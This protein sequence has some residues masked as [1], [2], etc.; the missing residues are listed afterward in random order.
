MTVRLL[1]C[2]KCLFFYFLYSS[3]NPEKNHNS[4]NRLIRKRVFTI[5]IK[6]VTLLLDV[7]KCGSKSAY[8]KLFLKNN[9]PL[10]A[11][12]GINYFFKYITIENIYF[13]LNTIFILFFILVSSYSLN[14]AKIS[15]WQT[16]DYRESLNPLHWGKGPF[17]YEILDLLIIYS[18]NELLSVLP[19]INLSNRLNV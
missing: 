10:A 5:I 2:Y 15:F 13:K 7:P 14:A 3:N 9:V 16:S 11:I 12:T 4:S 18:I 8:Y 1:K 6:N 19:N 17:D